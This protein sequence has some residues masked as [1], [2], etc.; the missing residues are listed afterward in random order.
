MSGSDT[1]L[2]TGAS[3]QLGRLV[4]DALLERGAQ[5][6]IGTTRNPEALAE[7]AARG[8]DVRAGD[9][10][11][12]GSLPEAF[13]GATHLLL[14]ST[15]VVGSRS[16]AHRSANE[17]AKEAGVRHIFYTSHASPDTSSSPVAPEHAITE[18]TILTSGLTYTILRNFLYSENLLLIL[19]QALAQDRFQGAAGDARVAWLTRKDCAEAAA[20][21][22]LNAAAHENRIYD[23]TGAHGYS[24]GDVAALLSKIVGRPIAY[25][26][27]TAD[28]YKAALMDRG[29]S[30]AA[31]TTYLNLELSLRSGEMEP[32][33]DVVKRLTGHEPTSLGSVLEHGRLTAEQSESL[34]FLRG[35][36]HG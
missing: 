24:Y 9:F 18:K 32:V 4:L 7:Y 13:S 20:G 33:N 12:P 36:P 28:A 5:H 25:E 6:V 26:D 35:E 1:F 16:D 27:L 2:V 30:D 8:V 15:H 21:A 19:P 34:A 22:M 11:K 31:A 10:T 3:G 14:I 29:L 23:V 17:A